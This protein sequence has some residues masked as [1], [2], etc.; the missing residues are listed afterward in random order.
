[1]DP[2]D[3]EEVEVE[4]DREDAIEDLDGLDRPLYE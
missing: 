4:E 3:E 1:M 2:K